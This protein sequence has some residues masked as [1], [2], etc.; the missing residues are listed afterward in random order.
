[1][2]KMILLFVAIFVFEE[3]LYG[4]LGLSPTSYMVAKTST[5]V[6]LYALLLLLIL[7]R[8]T[9]TKLPS[10]RISTFDVCILF[11]FGTV[12]ISLMINGGSFV[13]SALN[14]RT[15]LRY[16]AIY[17]IILLSGWVPIAGQ[18]YRF[19]RFVV[20]VAVI[21]SV[22]IVGQHFFGGDFIEAYF[23]PVQVEANIAGISKILGNADLKIGAGYGTFGKTSLA[24]FYLLFSAVM[25]VAMA[26]L[27]DVRRKRRWWFAYIII[28]IGIYFSYKRSALLLLMIAP[29][30]MA[31]IAGNGKVVRRWF[32]VAVISVPII[33]LVVLLFKPD[34]KLKE[35]AQEVSPVTSLAALMTE[36]YWEGSASHSRGWMII[37]VGKQ[38]FVAL[39]PMGYGADEE[40]AK[41]QLSKLG[42]EF[43]KLVDW[44]AFDDVYIVAGLIYYGPVGI[45]FL[46]YAYYFIYRRGKDLARLKTLPMYRAA[47]AT[48]A[49]SA[50]L[51]LLSVFVSRVP[52][53][54]AYSFCFWVLSGMVVAVVYSNQRYS[55]LT[56]CNAQQEEDGVSEY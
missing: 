39:K 5:E 11:F 37:E 22:L 3:T 17:Y 13:Y 30:I 19:A 29:L 34:G 36:E 54:R 9:Q 25:S 56:T 6:F 24:A 23:S 8:F 44:G 45:G 15:M 2:I 7:N 21:Q 47:G 48:L 46:I 20:I 41:K 49:T 51:L 4:R 14:V 12:L 52:E 55:T 38:A 31:F 16:V 26:L 1:M 53:F 40:N 50:V 27:G 32:M 10:Y 33:V 35:K 42:G 18:M 28:F 43:G